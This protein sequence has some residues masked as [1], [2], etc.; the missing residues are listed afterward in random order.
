M[1]NR[2]STIENCFQ[3]TTFEQIGR[4]KQVFNIALC[5][6]LLVPFLGT[7]GWLHLEKRQVRKEI[8]R[9]IIA[10]IDKN[11]L[12]PLKFS[13]QETQSELHWH[14]SK[15]F[16]Y[17]GEMYD[18]VESETNGDSISYWCWWDKAETALNRQLAELVAQS[19]QQDPENT[20]QK[21]RLADF[22]KTLIVAQHGAQG[23]EISDDCIRPMIDPSLS[24]HLDTSPPP[25]PPPERV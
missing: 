13:A 25:Y 4:L 10:G 17:R 18:I 3:S 5:L 7:Y 2:Q 21:Q 23:H 8:K 24:P 6:C 15:E 16:E 1:E 20:Q 11:A 9:Q 22:L 12:V 19:T 14:H